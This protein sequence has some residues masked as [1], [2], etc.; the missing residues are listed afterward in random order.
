MVD[1]R[2][3]GARAEADLK[4]KLREATGLN[5][6]RTPGSGALNETHKLK[7]DIYIPNEKNKFCI[8]VKHYKD[9]HLTSKILTDKEP[10]L[11]KWWKQ[12]LDQAAKVDMLPLLFFK[13]DR[14]KWFVAFDCHALKNLSPVSDKY[15]YIEYEFSLGTYHTIFIATMEAWIESEDIEWTL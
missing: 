2:Q 9:D 6:Q 1:S 13:K 3:K 15:R 14:G 11:V 5:F 10:Q 7:G 12:T 4:K 8:E